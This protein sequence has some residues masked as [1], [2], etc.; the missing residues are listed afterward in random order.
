MATNYLAKP[1]D[2]ETPNINAF[3]QPVQ[4]GIDRYNKQTQVYEEN[5]RADEQLGMQRERLGMARTKAAREDDDA[6]IT[7]WGREANAIHGLQGPQRQAAWTQWI[8]S[9]PD[10][11]SHAKARGVDLNDFNSGPQFIAT[12][13]GVYDADKKRQID[14]QIASSQAST[15]ASNAQLQQISRQ[16]PE[17]RMQNAGRFGID[18]NTPEG[19]AFVISGQ[20]AP[21]DELTGIIGGVVRDALKPT[22]PQQQSS[23]PLLQP[24]SFAD[25]PQSDPNLIRVQ[26]PN[27]QPPAS[28][29]PPVGSMFDGKTPEQKRRIGEALMLDPRTK[30]LGEQLMKDTDR[31]R[32]ELGKTAT[33]DIDE[34]IVNGL[35]VLTRMEGIADSFKPEFQ[36]IGT[37]MGMAGAGW[38]AKIDPSRIDPKTAAQLAEFSTYRRR[39][40]ENVN[41]TIKE[42]TGAAMSIPEAS[43][44]LSQV[45]NAGTGIFDGDD[46]ITF[47]A[48]MDD[49]VKQSRLVVARQAWLKKNNP[50]LLDQLARNK[51]AGVENIMPLNKMND[52]MNERRNQIYQDLKQRSPNASRDQLLPF[53]G[54]QLKQE[55]GI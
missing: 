49:V 24:Q 32:S 35:N 13:A 1:W 38:M 10:L 29:P 8:Q 50:Q 23:A 26:A 47:K 27:A 55:F 25:G 48:K 17:W 46:P 41:T 34:K 14:A 37:R 52:M 33:N 51:M 7:R 6:K 45:P 15:A 42:I 30:A 19:K 31:E 43:R 44:I 9:N 53:V 40:S 21:K 39:A 5:R 54:Q 16:T 18:V 3:F 4:Q 2:F 11:A 22:A 20:Y 36:T 28:L 12:E